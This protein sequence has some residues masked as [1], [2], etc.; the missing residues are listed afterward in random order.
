MRLLPLN[1][2]HDMSLKGQLQRPSSPSRFHSTVTSSS[3]TPRVRLEEVTAS[4][5]RSSNQ[6]FVFQRL[7]GSKLASLGAWSAVHSRHLASHVVGISGI[8]SLSMFGC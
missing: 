7:K 5:L 2:H 3:P 8:P 6:T 4:Q 1:L